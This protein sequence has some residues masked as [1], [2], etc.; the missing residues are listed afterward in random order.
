MSAYLINFTKT[1]LYLF[2]V[3]LLI[4]LLSLIN[5]TRTSFARENI[6]SLIKLKSGFIEASFKKP[7]P[8]KKYSS[9]SYEFIEIDIR[10]TGRKRKA[11]T[12]LIFTTN[13]IAI[14]S[15]TLLK[16]KKSRTLKL[17]K[18]DT[19]Y[20]LRLPS[21]SRYKPITL[22]I[23]LKLQ[24][25]TVRTEQNIFSPYS[26]LAIKL[27]PR[28]KQRASGSDSA[29]LIW[30][31][32]NCSQNYHK[33][34]T[35]IGGEV[36]PLMKANLKRA[37]KKT[38]R[39]NSRWLFKPTYKYTY[40]TVIRKKCRRYRKI[41]DREAHKVRYKCKSYKRVK[42]RIRSSSNNSSEN[43]LYR[44]ANEFIS[45]RARQ[46]IL[47]RNGSHY[48]VLNKIKNDF[49]LYFTQK[50]NPS[51]CTGALQFTDYYNG[52][53]NGIRKKQK[54]F[55]DL[56]KEGYDL[57]LLNLQTYSLAIK[58][59]TNER[60]NNEY[61]K[62]LLQRI[63]NIQP[64]FLS[65]VKKKQK[66]S[67]RLKRLIDKIAGTM[68]DRQLSSL[69]LNSQS[70]RES[71]VLIKKNIKKIKNTLSPFSYQELRNTL[72]ILEALTVIKQVRNEYKTLTSVVDDSIRKIRTSHQRNCSCK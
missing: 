23:E 21:I 20:K 71:L 8:T 57:A 29:K 19:G 50:H 68:E 72:S 59:E 67:S 10:N 25:D 1:L 62:S 24:P 55:T 70:T 39:F 13:K 36:I 9:G 64:V 27:L 15:A 45:T 5:T 33:S 32:N 65:K 56:Y 63:S 37:S 54:R 35:S 26:E 7:E 2:S 47:S 16:T 22:L 41:W 48:W 28:K 69:I 49:N 66:S 46:S 44:A 53:L 51:I 58:E 11:N 61:K 40:K 30:H 38:N 4:V 14:R 42:K 31:L 34:L 6:S 12:D 52:K 3:L 18:T 43:K 60:R 17:I